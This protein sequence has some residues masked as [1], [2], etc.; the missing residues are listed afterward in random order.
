MWPATIRATDQAGLF[1]ENTFVVTVK[2]T[3]TL[4]LDVRYIF[5]TLYLNFEVSTL[6][7]VDWNLW[8]VSG[9]IVPIW[10]IPLPPIDPTVTFT[11]PIPGF[12]QLGPVLFFTNMTTP[13]GRICSDRDIAFTG[14]GPA[15]GAEA[16]KLRELFPMP[17]GILSNER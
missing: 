17:N 14:S 5:G 7:S 13:D 9:R 1:V 8:L 6:E 11:L 12:P 4:N 2:P 3:C 16:E 15:E 10:S